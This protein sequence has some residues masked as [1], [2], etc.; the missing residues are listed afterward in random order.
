MIH[1]TEL[2]FVHV[3]YIGLLVSLHVNYKFT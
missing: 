1:Y 3:L 2:T